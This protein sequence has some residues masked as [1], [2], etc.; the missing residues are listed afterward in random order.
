MK[1]FHAA[2]LA[3]VVA[4]L[5]GRAD[6]DAVCMD[7]ETFV[8][9]GRPACEYLR[10]RPSWKEELCPTI[11]ELYCPVTCGLCYVS[12]Y[13]TVTTEPINDST[14]TTE[15]TL[16]VPQWEGAPCDVVCFTGCGEGLEPDLMSTY[17][18]GG[19]DCTATNGCGVHIHSGFSCADSDAQGGHWYD[20]EMVMED[21]WKQVGYKL[22]TPDGTAEF[23]DCVQVGFDVKS[24]PGLLE[25]R[26]F[27]VHKN[28]GGRASCGLMTAI[29]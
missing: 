22:T 4:A 9:R 7:D 13:F 19:D 3:V 21:P 11:G 27:V 18:G 25:G 2:I 16:F 6:A 17:G 29:A 14:I 5:A 8:F 28:D 20:S 1:L 10:I 24:D 23:A 26:A 15:T 12:E